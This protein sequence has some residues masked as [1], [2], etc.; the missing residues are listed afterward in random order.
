MDI[1]SFIVFTFNTRYILRWIAA[2][3]VLFIPV[4]NFLSLGYLYRTAGLSLVGGIGLPTWERKNEALKEGAKFA[5]IVILYWALPCFL[6]SFAFLLKSFG[7][8]ITVPIADFMTFLAVLAFIFCSFFIPFAFCAAVEAMEV[9]AAFELERIARATK[10]VFVPYV[11]GYVISGACVYVAYKL[12]KIPYL[13][14]FVIS[15]IMIFYIL[16]VSTYY[17]TQLF[18]RTSLSKGS[19]SSSDQEESFEGDDPTA[20]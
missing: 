7:N 8:V 16:L 18:K 19:P 6:F 11:L 4:V 10:E 17:F 1:I 5:Y 15:S 13:L 2:G 20:G 14:G 9:R 3:A 12:H